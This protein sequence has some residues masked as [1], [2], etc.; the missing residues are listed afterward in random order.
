[1]AAEVMIMGAYAAAAVVI[2]AALAMCFAKPLRG[3]LRFL[4]NFAFGTAVM[5]VVNTAF[6][7]IAVGINPFTAFS[8]GVLG[9]PGTVMV[10]ILKNL[11]C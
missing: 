8:S 11:I 1:M 2:A 10:Y 3:V 4:L 6:P 9:F 7:K 5:F